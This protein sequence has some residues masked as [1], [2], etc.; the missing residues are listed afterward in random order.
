MFGPKNDN[1]QNV[2]TGEGNGEKRDDDGLAVKLA[3][4]KR[5]HREKIQE[6]F[7]IVL[8]RDAKQYEID[9]ALKYIATETDA[10]KAY[11]NLVWALINTKEFMY[12]H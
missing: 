3:A 11:G 7:E 5:E 9:E 6:L 1:E 2:Y 12:I 8:S 4:D 10:K